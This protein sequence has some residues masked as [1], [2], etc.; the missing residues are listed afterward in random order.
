MHHYPA[1]PRGA[2]LARLA[3]EA[4]KP[5]HVEKARYGT[6]WHFW[7]LKVNAG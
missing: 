6:L 5:I 4:K 1:C 3:P 7:H 2:V